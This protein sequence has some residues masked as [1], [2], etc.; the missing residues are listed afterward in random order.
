L[1]WGRK[2]GAVVGLYFKLW[3]CNQPSGL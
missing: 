3:T 1:R 2:S